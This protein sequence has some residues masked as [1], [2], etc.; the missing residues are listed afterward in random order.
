MSNPEKKDHVVGFRLDD[1]YHREL[2]NIVDQEGGTKAEVAE[3]ATIQYLEKHHRT[4]RE[5]LYMAFT[6]LVA[7]GI[8]ALLAAAG[9][10]Q[11]AAVT[12]VAYSLIPFAAP[13]IANAA[14]A[15]NNSLRAVLG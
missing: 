3:Q 4:G 7:G 12:V 15:V 10:T 5:R 13:F 2:T 6:F 1:Q 14:S 9:N 11:A 8:P